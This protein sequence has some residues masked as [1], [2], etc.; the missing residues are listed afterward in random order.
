MENENL[1]LMQ[2]IRQEKNCQDRPKK[3]LCLFSQPT[4]LDAAL[5]PAA[6]EVVNH[7]GDGCDHPRQ[8][9]AEKEAFHRAVGGDDEPDPNETQMP[10]RFTMVGIRDRPPRTR[11]RIPL[12][13]GRG[14]T[15]RLRRGS[16]ACCPLVFSPA[17]V[18]EGFQR[19][20]GKPFGAP[21]GAYSCPG[22][23]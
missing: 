8:R 12:A 5:A 13:P 3:K 11:R 10:V 19:A 22:G 7:E 18:P 4:F 9:I 1:L 17:S 16:R 20:N 2:R 14:M 21:A 23:E 15:R 6:L